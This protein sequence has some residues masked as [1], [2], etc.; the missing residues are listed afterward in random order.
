MLRWFGLIT[1]F[2][3]KYQKLMFNIGVSYHASLLVAQYLASKGVLFALAIQSYKSNL[4]DLTIMKEDNKVI[5]ST[6]EIRCH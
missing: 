1:N 6:Y 5:N 3:G 4:K 2:F